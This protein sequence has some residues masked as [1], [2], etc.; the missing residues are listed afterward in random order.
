VTGVLEQEANTVTKS[1]APLATIAV[2]GALGL[3]AAGSALGT[4]ARQ[5]T[6]YQITATMTAK[7]I[8]A[9]RPA[10]NVAKARGLLRGSVTLAQRSQIAWM[11]TYSGMTGRV[12][13]ALVLFRN[14]KGISTAISLCVTPCKSGLRS[15]TFFSS[16]AE[17]VQFVK[18][19]LAG[20]VD[21][22]LKTK[23][24]PVGEVRGVLK[25]REG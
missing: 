24:N 25:A 22:V 13:S 12:V 18:Q 6:A 9:P 10:G 15:F 16:R 23:R 8:T 4:T 2:T 19:V 21:V 14:A 5:A 7:Q 3:A 17:A 11:L 20:K 1:W